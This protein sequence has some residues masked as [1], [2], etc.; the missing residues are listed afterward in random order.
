[1]NPAKIVVHVMEGNR[2]L[3]ILQFL[4]ERVR[5]PRESAHRHSYREVLPLNVGRGNVREVGPAGDYRPLRPMQIA[6]L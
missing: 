6:G 5:Q 1:M 2:M 3:Q 4:A